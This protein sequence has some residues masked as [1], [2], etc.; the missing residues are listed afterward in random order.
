MADDINVILQEAERLSRTARDL[1]VSGRDTAST[2]QRELR[3]TGYRIPSAT[4][5]V[6]ELREAQELIMGGTATAPSPL[7]YAYGAIPTALRVNQSPGQRREILREFAEDPASSTYERVAREAGAGRTA[8]RVAGF[9]GEAADP[10][11]PLGPVG[12]A[13][14][15]IGMPALLR[16]AKNLE[17]RGQR[18]NSESGVLS[19]V[20]REG[21]P[22]TLSHFSA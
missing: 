11:D 12:D 1:A 10:F 20:G 4:P 15:G 2:Q 18:I 21:N 14:L 13:V 22:P 9:A 6:Q 19:Q 7:S 3:E 17:R 16:I 5:A 8:A